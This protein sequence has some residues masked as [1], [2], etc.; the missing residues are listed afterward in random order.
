MNTL[1]NLLCLMESLKKQYGTEES[2]GREKIN[3]IIADIKSS[4]KGRLYDCTFV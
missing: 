3:A 1:I 4:G 2:K